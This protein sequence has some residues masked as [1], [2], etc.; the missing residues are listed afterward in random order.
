MSCPPTGQVVDVEGRLGMGVVAIGVHPHAKQAGEGDIQPK[1]F[2]DFPHS[3]IIGMLSPITESAGDV[4]VVLPWLECSM[5]KK[6]LAQS[7][8]KSSLTIQLVVVSHILVL[9]LPLLKSSAFL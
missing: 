3:R 8:S 7:M 9:A 6:Y 2:L 4:P 1:L 5:K